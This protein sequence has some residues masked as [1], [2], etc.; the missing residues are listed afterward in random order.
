MAKLQKLKTNDQVLYWDG[1]SFMELTSVKEVIKTNST[2]IL[3]NGIILN[4]T[5]DQDGTYSRADYKATLEAKEKKRRKIHIP[6]T[7]ISKA[8]LYEDERIKD[9]YKAYLFKKGSSIF[10]DNLKNRIF[11]IKYSDLTKDS[12]IVKEINNIEKKLKKLYEKIPN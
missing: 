6:L 12:G 10:L 5:P 8:W 2:A 3:D 9:M 1:D 4:R 7:T 11:K